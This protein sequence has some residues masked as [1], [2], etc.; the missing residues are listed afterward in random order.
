M[1]ERTYSED[2]RIY[3]LDGNAAR[4][5]VAFPGEEAPYE[6]PSR[7][8]E[9]RKGKKR[10]ALERS[11]SDREKSAKLSATP[12]VDAA[13][14]AVLCAALVIIVLSAASLL[15]VQS[16]I[17]AMNKEITK[18]NAETYALKT[19]NDHV[20]LTIEK[21]IDYDTILK[22]A[23]EELGMV[24]PYENQMIK[25]HC[26]D[27]GYVRQYGELIGNEEES[28]AKTFVKMLLYK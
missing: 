21:S 12:L 27:K 2:N 17:S 26:E 15:R 13:A 4:K 23:T 10:K 5:V 14:M 20:E 24:Y 22:V 25:Y 8:R 6:V 16:D 7:E 1:R 9:Q 18:I 3:E 11:Y 19:A 28:F